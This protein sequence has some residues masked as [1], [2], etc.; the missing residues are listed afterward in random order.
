MVSLNTVS[1]SS[2]ITG[3]RTQA[4]GGSGTMTFTPP[5]NARVEVGSQ[6]SKAW[7]IK[8]TPAIALPAAADSTDPLTLGITV[9]GIDT[10]TPLQ[11]Y[12]SDDSDSSQDC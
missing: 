1:L 11:E 9:G 3:G 8:Y 12:D 10:T 4:L 6:G 5:R 2:D 7:S